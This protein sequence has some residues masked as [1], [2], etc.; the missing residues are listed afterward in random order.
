MRVRS[1]PSNYFNIIYKV[2]SDYDYLNYF[3]L[4]YLKKHNN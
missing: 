4:L 3:T 1:K 2:N